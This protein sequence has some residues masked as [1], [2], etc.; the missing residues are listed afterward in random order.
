MYYIM[1]IIILASVNSIH[2]LR[3]ANALS[4][5]G[6][7]LHFI[8]SHD[9]K[10]K[11]NSN[12]KFH[13]LRYSSPG[14]YFLNLMSLKELMKQI[15]PDIL[16][17]HY[18]SGYGTLG[19]LS[20][21]SPYVLSVWGSDVYDFPKKS[22]F[23]RLLIEKNLCA[24]DWVCSTSQVMA[25]HTLSLCPKI[26]NLSVTPFGIDVNK[27]APSLACNNL[28]SAITIGTVKT[29]TPVYGIDILIK[30]FAQARRTVAT[31]SPKL[32]NN[33]RLLIVGDGS[34][35]KKL[36][37]LA[38]DVGI[39]DITNF[40]GCVSHIEVPAYMNQLD[41]YVAVSRLESFGVAVLEA[42][43]CR[44]PVIVSNIGGLPEVVLNEITGIIVERENI[45]ATANALVRLIEDSTLRDRMGKAG[46]KYVIEQYEWEENVT[47]MEKV[48][49]QVLNRHIV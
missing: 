22:P 28:S 32:A 7:K 23:H 18:A 16:H 40:T 43:A 15:N 17:A 13:K 5:R 1:E 24:A 25:K 37:L 46:R 3:W 36:E 9:G 30:A 2:A 6:H 35:R 44:L 41:I 42:S 34:E 47:R 33:L 14:G 8:S 19:R 45:Q 21:F 29:L 26:T 31:S 12:I 4:R 20:G 10:E 11:L 38:K 49:E 39:K 27:F 48:Y